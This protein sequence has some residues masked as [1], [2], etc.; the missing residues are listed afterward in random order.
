MVLVSEL[1]SL[2]VL[3]GRLRVAGRR[4]GGRARR[5]GCGRTTPSPSCSARRSAWRTGPSSGGSW[6]RYRSGCCTP[7]Y[8]TV[9]PGPELC[10][11]PPGRPADPRPRP[12]G[13]LGSRPVQLSP[14]HPARPPLPPHKLRQGPP[15]QP[16]RRRQ[17]LLQTSLLWQ[18][19]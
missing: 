19:Q 10:P 14:L 11:V 5:A 1:P 12:A 2:S 3:A 6:P 15:Q 18:T 4:V 8:W 9:S 16:R 7:L 17:P 13:G